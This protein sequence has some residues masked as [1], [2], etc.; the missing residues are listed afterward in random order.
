MIQRCHFVLYAELLLEVRE[1]QE[2]GRERQRDVC[3]YRGTCH[4][5]PYAC[6]HW[7]V[8]FCVNMDSEKLCAQVHIKRMKVPELQN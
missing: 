4:M 3:G 5:C 8:T 1:E 2:K 7:C 6:V